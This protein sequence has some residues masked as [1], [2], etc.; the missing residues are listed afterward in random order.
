EAMAGIGGDDSAR[1]IVAVQSESV[2][3][4]CVEPEVRVET[5]PK[6]LGKLAELRRFRPSER[7]GH[8]G[9]SE[10]R[11]VFVALDLGKGDRRLGELAGGVHDR[12]VG[13]LPSLIAEPDG[14]AARVSEISLVA[15][16]TEDPSECSFEAR[17]EL[18]YEGA[19]PRPPQVLGEE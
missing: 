17:P 1:R 15:R 10:E 7:V 3:A 13:V 11:R 6:A 2:E 4:L 16:G 8:L 19:V 14:R 9:R 18:A 12:V 5:V